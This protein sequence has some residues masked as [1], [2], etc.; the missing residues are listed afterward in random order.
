MKISMMKINMCWKPGRVCCGINPRSHMVSM[1]SHVN[2]GSLTYVAASRDHGL[3][4][5]Q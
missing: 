2:L 4:K 1:L 3:K 5:H